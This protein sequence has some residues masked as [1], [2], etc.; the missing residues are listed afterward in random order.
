MSLNYFSLQKKN[1]IAALNAMN[2]SLYI[3][4]MYADLVIDITANKVLK[5]RY[6]E[7]IPTYSEFVFDFIESKM[8]DQIK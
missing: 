8:G 2:G 7:K 4:V 1:M 3:C 6:C 5:S